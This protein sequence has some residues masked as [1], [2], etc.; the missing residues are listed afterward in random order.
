M[1]SGIGW[2]QW[3]IIS[4]LSAIMRR[5]RHVAVGVEMRNGVILSR[6]NNDEMAKIMSFSAKYRKCI[7]E[8]A[9]CGISVKKKAFC[10]INLGGAESGLKKKI[11]KI[12]AMA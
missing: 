12:I 2:P 3:R 7:N 8:M 11:V 1:A 5:N 4:W 10:K 9:K 6:R